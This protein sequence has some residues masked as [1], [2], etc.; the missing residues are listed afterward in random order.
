MRAGGI[1]PS[2]SALD[3]V[4]AQ[5]LALLEK[6]KPYPLAVA[7]PADFRCVDVATVDPQVVVTEPGFS[8]YCIDHDNQQALFTK[9]DV[10]LSKA[11]FLFQAQYKH[12]TGIVAVS[13]DELH[14]LATPGEPSGVFVYSTGRCGS[15]LVAGALAERGGLVRLS[16]PDVLTQLVMLKRRYGDAG[17]RKL[18]QSCVR[19]L[20]RG[21]PVAI[22][23][24]SFVIELAEL[25][26]GE[27]PHFPSIF[28]YREPQAW[29]RSTA[30]AFA[31]YDPA[32]TSD[33]AGV[34]D[35]LGSL[36]PLL[37]K[38]RRR[39]GRLLSAEEVMA[40]Q[41]VSQVEQAIALRHKGM[42][43]FTV[44]YEELMADPHGVLGAI[45]QH[46]GLPAPSGLDEVLAKDSQEGTTLSRAAT[47]PREG[48][49]H[50]A[51]FDGAALSH[52]MA[53]LWVETLR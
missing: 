5:R 33:P 7:G 8:L 28:L 47:R 18:T 53:E 30:R 27:F 44:S 3:G 16:E 41:W 52:A 15:T 20:S 45:F 29:G 19:L 43:I 21:K 26:H 22:K 51:G 1:P 24:R 25:L 12:A 42:N 34:Q 2:S 6:T 23:P 35:R 10:D 17:L 46:C 14:E 13:Y 39:L 4:M 48:Q 32:L 49:Q 40:C 9:T 31:G 11:P 36:I 37:A 50:G 38:R